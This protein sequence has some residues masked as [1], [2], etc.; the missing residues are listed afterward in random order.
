[1]IDV[2]LIFRYRTPNEKKLL[3]GGFN[4]KDGKF[5]KSFSIMDEQFSVEVQIGKTVEFKVSEADTGEEYVLVH[6]PDAQGG[7]VG[8]V[9]A[10]CEELLVFIAKNAFDEETFKT[11]QTKRIIDYVGQ[12][13]GAELEFLW[14]DTDA[15][16]F[17]HKE[18]TKWFGIIMIVGRNKL[19]LEGNGTIEIMNL[20]D[21]PLIIAERNDGKRFFPAYHMN[22]KH[23]Y[24]LCLDGRLSDEEIFP[25]IE[26]SFAVTMKK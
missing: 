16:I 26:K 19:G 3:D 12:K 23:W 6:V 2:D 9:R 14:D 18:N 1:M 20:K 13:Y 17:R 11:G 5:V 15:A 22:K 4:K 21:E 8:E 7:F 24:T 25:L 10:S